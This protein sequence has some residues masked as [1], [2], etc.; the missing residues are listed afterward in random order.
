MPPKRTKH[1][2]DPNLAGRYDF[3]ERKHLHVMLFT[4][5]KKELRIAALRMNMSMTQM[6]ERLAHAIIEED[7][8]ITKMLNKYRIDLDN[9]EASSF[10]KTDADSIFKA[11]EEE[12]I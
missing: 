10:S 2:K 11:I 6:F 8:Y 7:T 3:D 9:K 5:T 4:E 12:G 1:Y